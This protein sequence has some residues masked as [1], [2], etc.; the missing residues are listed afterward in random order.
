MKLLMLLALLLIVG[1][2]FSS[3]ISPTVVYSMKDRKF[4]N[5][6]FMSGIDWSLLTNSPFSVNSENVTTV[7]NIAAKSMKLSSGTKPSCDASTRGTFWITQGGL[8]VADTLELCVKT[9][10]DSYLWKSISLT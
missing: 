9:I 4:N 8:G 7:Y 5:F 2:A 1:V 6:V 10:L 3:S